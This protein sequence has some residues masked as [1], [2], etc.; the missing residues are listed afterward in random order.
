[1]IVSLLCPDVADLSGSAGEVWT[2][3]PN[4]AGTLFVDQL[5][6]ITEEAVAAGG[7]TTQTPVVSVEVGGTE[8]ATLTPNVTDGEAVGNQVSAVADTTN[9]EAAVG[10]IQYTADQ[11]ITVNIKTQG[12]GGTTTGTFRVFLLVDENRG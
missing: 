8:V 4:S 1:M 7:F 11:A 5:F 10:A 12:T 2:Y 9:V 3:T 6:A